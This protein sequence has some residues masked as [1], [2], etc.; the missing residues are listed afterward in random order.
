MENEALALLLDV[1]DYLLTQHR[2]ALETDRLSGDQAGPCDER[3][4]LLAALESAATYLERVHATRTRLTGS[5][6]SPS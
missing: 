1:A 2:R 6:Q 4:E 3:D 5:A